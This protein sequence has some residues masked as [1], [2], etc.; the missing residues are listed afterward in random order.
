MSCKFSLSD[1]RN[2]TLLHEAVEAES[3]PNVTLLAL[4][5]VTMLSARD[6]EGRTPLH[7][8]CGKGFRDILLF[9]LEIGADPQEKTKVGENCLEVAI[10][11]D[12]SDIVKELLLSKNWKAVSNI[13]FLVER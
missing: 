3:L 12:Q 2:L 7:I 11:N 6:V 1:N 10:N 5:E 9:L 4:D 8:A 13:I